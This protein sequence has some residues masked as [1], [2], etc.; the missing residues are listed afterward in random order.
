MTREEDEEWDEWLD[1]II[2]GINRN[3]DKESKA[4]KETPVPFSPGFHPSERGGEDGQVSTAAAEASAEA[5]DQA[6][7]RSPQPGSDADDPEGSR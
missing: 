2:T 6:D 3:K 5:G 1:S 4:T 7:P